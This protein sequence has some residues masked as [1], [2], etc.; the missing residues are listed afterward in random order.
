MALSSQLKMGMIH[1]LNSP[2]PPSWQKKMNTD[3]LGVKAPQMDAACTE[4]RLCGH[5]PE[6][7]SQ[8]CYFLAG[9]FVTPSLSILISRMG[10]IIALTIEG[11]CEDLST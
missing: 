2:G 5:T 10:I 7:H 1:C 11:G 8:L 3:L 6:G 4:H 9:C